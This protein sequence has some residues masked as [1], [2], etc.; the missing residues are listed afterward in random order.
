MRLTAQRGLRILYLLTDGYGGHGGIAAYNRDVIDALA[1]DDSIDEIVVVPRVISHA[2]HT[3]PGKVRHVEAAAGGMGRYL[4]SVAGLVATGRF[5]LVYCAHVN[6][7]PIALAAARLFRV[8]ML[9]TIYGIEAWRPS[10]RKLVNRAVARADLVASISQVTLDRFRTWSPVADDRTAILPNAI[11]LEK[12][13]AGPRDPALIARYGLGTRRVLMTFGRMDASE[14]YKGFDQVLDLIASIGVSHNL[15]YLLA[16]DGD[17]RSRL[18]QKAHE[19]GIADRVSFT[20][21]IAEA[22]KAAHYRVA[23]VYVMPSDGE[24]FGFVL[25]EALACGIPAIG[26]VTDG[27]REALRNGM[28]GRL[29]DPYDPDALRKAVTDALDEPRTIPD[30]LSYFAFPAFTARWRALVAR[31]GRRG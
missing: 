17:D 25:I 30:G 11:S 21:Y 26:S 10:P 2:I 19:L 15:H 23:D 6:L 13:G 14:R 1:G 12:F 29:V 4:A 24:G 28:L 20:G 18:E 22:E 3:V 9:L 31:T 5:D 16:G 27:G 8:P 7:A